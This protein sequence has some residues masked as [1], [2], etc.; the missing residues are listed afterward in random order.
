[1]IIGITGTDGAGKGTVVD[2]LVSQLGFVHYSSRDLIMREVEKRGLEPNRINARIVGNALRAE[3]GPDVIVKKALEQITKDGVEKAVIESIRAVKEA[4]ALK[5]AGGI[6]L[7]VDAPTEVRYER[8]VGRGSVTD[9]V[10]FIDFQKQEAL[11]MDDPDP[12]GM[13]KAK[14][15]QMANQ[16]IFNDCTL[17]ELQAVVDQFLQKYSK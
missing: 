11:E 14:V 15:M 7:A 2:Y 13:Q 10:S 4:E 3:F 16:I 6:L 12:N 5:Q 1:M 17:L 8:I 9:Q